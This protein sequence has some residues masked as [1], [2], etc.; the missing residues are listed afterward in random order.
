M[1]NISPIKLLRG[2]HHDTARTGHGCVMNVIS[3]LQ[4]DP[5]IT[6]RPAGVCPAIRLLAV[7]LNDWSSD[8]QRQRLIPFIER[9][10]DSV[11]PEVSMQTWR[12]AQAERFIAHA[13]GG[14]WRHISD[15]T[16]IAGLQVLD[17][18]CPPHK[19]ATTEVQARAQALIETAQRTS[20]AVEVFYFDPDWKSCLAAKPT[21]TKPVKPPA[22]WYVKHSK[23]Y[24][25]I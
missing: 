14:A 8:E 1:L 4:G 9:M 18:I 20:E 21:L 15:Y 13:G 23:H 24:S 5:I 10:M 16:F 22:P 7:V 3:Y 2:S 11:A 25:Y 19:D 12:I 6:D 17:T